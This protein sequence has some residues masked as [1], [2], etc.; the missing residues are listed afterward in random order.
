MA[1][2][3]KM[4][5]ILLKMTGLFQHLPIG[6][7]K[8]VAGAYIDYK[9]KSDIKIKIKNGNI[10][11]ETEGPCIFIANHLSNLDGVV[12]TKLL[13]KYDP[14]FVAGVK[15]SQ[16]NFTNFFKHVIKTI[17]IK[18][19]SADIDSMRA[20]VNTIKNRESVMMFP[21]GTRSRTGAMS[22]AK[23]G[24]LLIAK[25]TK[26]TIVPIALMG[27]EKVLPVNTAGEMSKERPQTG[28]IKVV[29]GEPFKVRDKR[30]DEDKAAY[31]DEVLNNIMTSIAKNLDP[32]YRGF[33]KDKIQ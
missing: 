8:K 22:E 5:D 11:K 6:M 17:E 33:Y 7:Q 4:T 13:K 28:E 10:L 21:E 1:R 27:T 16:D 31:E 2:I 29:V 26:A 19:N 24:I 3:S 32:E 25:M 30:K 14:Y 18:P 12:L 15:L 9:F 20:I 23:K